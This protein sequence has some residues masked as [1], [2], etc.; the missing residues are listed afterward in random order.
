MF[1]FPSVAMSEVVITSLFILNPLSLT[2]A[3]AATSRKLAIRPRRLMVGGTVFVERI[4]FTMTFRSLL[5]S[6]LAHFFDAICWFKSSALLTRVEFI[7]MSHILATI[8][9]A[10]IIVEA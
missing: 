5:T 2:F 7:N 4:R 3:F 8:I 9:P 6:R 10:R 1:G